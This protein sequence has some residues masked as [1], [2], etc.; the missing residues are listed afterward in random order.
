MMLYGYDDEFIFA[1]LITELVVFDEHLIIW[2]KKLSLLVSMVSLGNW[3]KNNMLISSTSKT[4]SQLWVKA[5]SPIFPN[6]IS[7]NLF[8]AV[9]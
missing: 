7:N 4:A 2:V 1:E 3:D 8:I 5:H 9:M 6:P